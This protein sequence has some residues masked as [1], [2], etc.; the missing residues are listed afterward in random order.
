LVGLLKNSGFRVQVNTLVKAANRAFLDS[1]PDIHEL[2]ADEDIGRHRSCDLFAKNSSER[3]EPG[4]TLREQPQAAQVFLR[5]ARL[6]LD[7]ALQ[8]AGTEGIG[9]VVEGNGDAASVGV[10]LMAMASA[11]PLEDESVL[12]QGCREPAR[13]KRSQ[14]TV[15]NT[16]TVTVTTGS[17]DVWTF[18]GMGS[19]SSSI[20]SITICATSRIFVRASSRVLPQVEAPFASNSGTYARQTSSSGSM[21]TRTMYVFMF[22]LR[23]TDHYAKVLGSI[24][25]EKRPPSLKGVEVLA[26]F[27]GLAQLRA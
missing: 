22:N 2:D 18:R 23:A 14:L 10:A 11:L 8:R 7:H 27:Q 21:T 26:V 1:C 25:R 16:H 12:G 24:F 15:F 9:C 13:G 5:P 17:S 3:E 6:R 4:V 20:D 19:P